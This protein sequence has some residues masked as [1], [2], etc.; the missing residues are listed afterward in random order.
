MDNVMST[1]TFWVVAYDPTSDEEHMRRAL[2][3]D[4]VMDE[5]VFADQVA[6]TLGVDLDTSDGYIPNCS[7]DLRVEFRRDPDNAVV[8]WSGKSYFFV[9]EEA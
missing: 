7:G 2:G 6:D 9:R 5:D 1:E 8:I 3:P 4:E